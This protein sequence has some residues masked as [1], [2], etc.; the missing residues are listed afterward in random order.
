MMMLLFVRKIIE[1]KEPLDSLPFVW[2]VIRHKPKDK[3]LILNTL[4]LFYPSP[5]ASESDMRV[6][7]SRRGEHRLIQKADMEREHR[8]DSR[9][10]SSS[11]V[12]ILYATLS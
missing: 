3:D 10:S 6:T 8:L 1:K 11:C 7:Y 9:A 5:W 12:K 2:P 4:L